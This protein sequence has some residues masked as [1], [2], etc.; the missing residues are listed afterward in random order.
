MTT[1]DVGARNPLVH[2][3]AR[4]LMDE[5]EAPELQLPEPLVPQRLAMTGADLDQACELLFE[6]RS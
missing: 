5:E 3:R 2:V 1:L 6:R 4:E